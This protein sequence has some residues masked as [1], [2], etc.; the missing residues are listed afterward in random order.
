MHTPH[1]H[2][3]ASGNPQRDTNP[4]NHPRWVGEGSSK[5]SRL[6]S[7]QC[8]A[9]PQA[10]FLPCTVIISQPL[11]RHEVAPCQ[12]PCNETCLDRSKSPHTHT[13]T[14]AHDRAS[15]NLQRDT[16]PNSHPRWMGE[17]SSKLSRL[18]SH[19]CSAS[20]QAFLPCTVLIS[21]PSVG[22]RLLRAR[23]H[24]AMKHA[25]CNARQDTHTHGYLSLDTSLTRWRASSWRA[26]SKPFV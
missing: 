14:H 16:N 18:K 1:A 21:Q 6:K 24:H 2:D 4:N 10:F 5:L 19:Q 11:C 13:H 17:G 12:A 25:H 8:S 7:H 3:R 9:S 26:P 22:M 20:P 23:W 15:G